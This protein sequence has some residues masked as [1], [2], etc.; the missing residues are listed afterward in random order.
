MASIV[1]WLS[2]VEL[3]PDLRPAPPARFRFDILGARLRSAPTLATALE[4]IQ[5]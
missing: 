2:V 1:N 3:A 5:V 4:Q